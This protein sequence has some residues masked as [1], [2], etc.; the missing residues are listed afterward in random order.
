MR[1]GWLG[2]P[3]GIAPLVCLGRERSRR[4]ALRRE[5]AP[6]WMILAAA[7]PWGMAR[8]GNAGSLGVQRA[9]A[10]GRAMR[11]DNP[12]RGE[13]TKSTMEYDRSAR[14]IHEGELRWGCRDCKQG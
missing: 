1:I 12:A 4:V 3:A 9:K 11:G 13:G 2:V 14:W 10:C 5:S 6:R 7:R 8:L